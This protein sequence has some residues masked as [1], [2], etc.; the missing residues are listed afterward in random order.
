MGKNRR[1]SKRS[2]GPRALTFAADSL[3]HIIQKVQSDPPPLNLRP[4][5]DIVVPLVGLL[6]AVEITVQDIASAIVSQTHCNADSVFSVMKVRFWAAHRFQIPSETTAAGSPVSVTESFYS[7][8]TLT[9]A[10][11]GTLGQSRAAVG[12]SYP[13][14]LRPCYKVSGDSN[15]T[16]KLFEFKDGTARPSLAYFSVRLI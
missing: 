13:P 4:W 14:N 6:A 1:K 7:V 15:A 9:A 10:D 8:G 11:A 5:R 2:R 12:F 16:R 3:P